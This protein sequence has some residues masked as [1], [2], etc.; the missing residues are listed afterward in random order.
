VLLHIYLVWKGFDERHV[1]M[2]KLNL[3]HFCCVQFGLRYALTESGQDSAYVFD[4]LTDLG[5]CG[6]N[7][8]SWVQEICIKCG[9]Q[10]YWPLSWKHSLEPIHCLPYFFVQFVPNRFISFTS[11]V[12]EFWKVLLLPSFTCL[13]RKFVIVHSFSVVSIME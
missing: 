2:K 1:T 10:S 4:L 9:F 11:P 6:A 5:L 12:A 7:V 13:L 8:Q 3:S